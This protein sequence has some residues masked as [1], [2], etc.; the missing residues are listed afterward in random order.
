MRKLL[1]AVVALAAIAAAARVRQQQQPD[2]APGQGGNASW[3]DPLAGTIDQFN[4]WAIMERNQTMQDAQDNNVQAM[5]PTIRYSE[6]TARAADPYRVCYGYRHTIADLS[7]HPAITGE[8]KGEPL[9][10]L[11][12]AYKGLVST[13][14]GAYQ[15]TRATWLDAK[16]ALGLTDFSPASQDAAAVWLI[17]KCAALDDLEAGRFDSAVRKCA[18]RWASLPGSTSGQPTRQLA[19]LEQVY[20]D[21]GGA[22]A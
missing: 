16:K 14:A 6:G 18:A 19:S 7:D 1:L 2:A 21:A 20:T 11:G 17:G 4:P 9:D 8:W 15:I 13:A 3:T 12:P 5:L 22:I 10:N